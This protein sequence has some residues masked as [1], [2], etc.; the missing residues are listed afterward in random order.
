MPSTLLFVLLSFT[1]DLLLS[2]H[3]LMAM[4]EPVGY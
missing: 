4:A 3:L 2:I 1:P